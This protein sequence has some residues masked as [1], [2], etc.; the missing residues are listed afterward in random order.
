MGC[1]D[2]TCAVV[3]IEHSIESGPEHLL[4]RVVVVSQ[5]E[6]VMVKFCRIGLHVYHLPAMPPSSI[7]AS[8]VQVHQVGVL[9]QKLLVMGTRSI[10]AVLQLSWSCCAEDPERLGR[11]VLL[12]PYKIGK[13][14]IVTEVHQT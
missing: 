12:K 6:A 3:K 11:L 14:L 8:G 13:E 10:A 2:L 9:A 7:P 5:V 4:V 1:L